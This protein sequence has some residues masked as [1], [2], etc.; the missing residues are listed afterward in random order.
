MLLDD[1]AARE[2]CRPQNFAR[3]RRAEALARAKRATVPQIALAFA[4]R[5]PL[6]PMA[7]CSAPVLKELASDIR[8]LEITLAEEEIRWLEEGEM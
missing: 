5:Q 2:Y 8:A 7:V 1:L 4:L 3:L 6:A